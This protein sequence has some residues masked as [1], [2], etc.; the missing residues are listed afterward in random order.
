MWYNNS[1]FHV[2]NVSKVNVFSLPDL[3]LPLMTAENI[4]I[5]YEISL[6]VDFAVVYLEVW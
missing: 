1:F 5:A 3:L 2:W 6:G 4:H